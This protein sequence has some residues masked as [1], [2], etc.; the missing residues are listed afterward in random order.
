MFAADHDGALPTLRIGTSANFTFWV[1]AIQ[2]YLGQPQLIPWSN[3]SVYPFQRCPA[4]ARSGTFGDYGANY[5]HVFGNY[6]ATAKRLVNFN[7]PSRV[8]LVGDATSGVT[9]GGDWQMFC[10]VEGGL[11]N[12]QDIPS[13]RH[14]GG[15]NFCFVDGHV[16]NFGAERIKILLA[17]PTADQDYWG[18][19]SL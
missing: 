5:P 1:L 6:S 10:P 15:G 8:I 11:N 19:F 17:A 16:E 7:R 9:R 3:P 2:P 18:H 14:Q 4:E 13:T 12:S